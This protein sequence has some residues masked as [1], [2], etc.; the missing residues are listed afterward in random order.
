MEFRFEIDGRCFAI[1]IG[2]KT[3]WFRQRPQIMIIEEWYG[4]SLNVEY[5]EVIWQKDKL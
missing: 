1:S 2:H 4:D 5:A 3:R